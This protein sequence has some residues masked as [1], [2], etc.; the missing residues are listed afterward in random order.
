MNSKLNVNAKVWDCV[1]TYMVKGRRCDCSCCDTLQSS[2][3]RL[4]KN[5]FILTHPNQWH[6]AKISRRKGRINRTFTVKEAQRL[7]KLNE[8]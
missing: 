4:L 3:N 2:L 1:R 8:L 7:L 5:D 6:I